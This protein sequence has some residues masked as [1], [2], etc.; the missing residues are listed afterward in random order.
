MPRADADAAS[1]VELAA[2][3]TTEDETSAISWW[4]LGLSPTTVRRTS[5]SQKFINFSVSCKL[6]V[7]ATDINTLRQIGLENIR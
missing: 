2:N 5:G 3:N 6:Q 1:D 4:R 7:V